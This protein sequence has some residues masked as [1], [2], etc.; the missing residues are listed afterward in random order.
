MDVYSKVVEKLADEFDA[1]FVD[2]QAAFDRYLTYRPSQSLSGDRIHPN[3]TG[4]IIIANAFLEAV[5]L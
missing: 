2:T 3:K 1:V 5:K 4:H